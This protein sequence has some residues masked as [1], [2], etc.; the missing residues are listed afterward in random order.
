MWWQPLILLWLKYNVLSIQHLLNHRATV[1]RYHTLPSTT[2]CRGKTLHDKLW[3]GPDH[4]SH[5][6]CCIAAVCHYMCYWQSQ[7]S[8]INSMCYTIGTCM[9]SWIV[10]HLLLLPVPEHIPI[11]MYKYYRNIYNIHC[12]LCIYFNIPLGNFVS[13]LKCSKHVTQLINKRKAVLLPC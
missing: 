3:L 9:W 7:C 10:P 13:N 11:Y 8:T 5:L 6:S 4:W 2:H 12:I 1:T